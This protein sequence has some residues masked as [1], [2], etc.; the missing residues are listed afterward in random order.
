VVTGTPLSAACLAA[1]VALNL[2]IAVVVNAMNDAEP[3]PAQ[4][5]AQADLEALRGEPAAVH[6]KLDQLL[7]REHA[8][9]APSAGPS[10]GGNG[11][12]QSSGVVTAG[13]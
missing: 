13:G 10:S 6:A 11:H 2:F 4:T 8:G 3:S 9:P 5:R 1:F 12:V 7:T